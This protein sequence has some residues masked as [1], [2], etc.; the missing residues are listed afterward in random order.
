MY[1]HVGLLASEGVLEVEGE[2][3]VHGAVERRY[4]LRRERAVIDR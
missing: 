1:R 2:Q 4:R 3:R